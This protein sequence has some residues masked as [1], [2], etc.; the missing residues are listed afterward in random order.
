[1]R[2]DAEGMIALAIIMIIPT[3]LE[4]STILPLL[5]LS[6]FRSILTL[7][8]YMSFSCR[9]IFVVLIHFF[10]FFIIFCLVIRNQEAIS[11]NGN[12]IKIFRV[13]VIT[14]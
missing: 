8:A 2:A 14:K 5:V 13:R 9:F 7:L 1:M 12:F 10:V 3:F 4:A 11:D 6:S